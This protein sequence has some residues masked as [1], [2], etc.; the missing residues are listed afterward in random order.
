[1]A[2]FARPIGNAEGVVRI[3]RSPANR[4]NDFFVLP[5]YSTPAKRLAGA[6]AKGE[7]GRQRLLPKVDSRVKEPHRLNLANGFN[8]GEIR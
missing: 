2:A 4:A 3:S 7:D 1:M 5:D 8:N 6:A